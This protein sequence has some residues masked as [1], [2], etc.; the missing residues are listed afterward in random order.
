MFFFLST[1]SL[2]IGKHFPGIKWGSEN[3]DIEL[4][5][6]CDPLCSDCASVWPQLNQLV[7]MYK[8]LQIR[9]HTMPLS[10]HTWSYHSVK[11]VQA[12]KLLKGESKA[13]DMLDA[14]YNGDQIQFLNSR[15][16]NTSESGAIDKFCDYVSSKFGVDRAEYYEM[17][18]SM[19]TRKAAGAESTFAIIHGVLGTPTY[20]VNGARIDF[21]EETTTE[22]WTKFLDTLV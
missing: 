2:C 18:N 22:E 5:V 8:T 20:D 10:I 11:A 17:F 6:Y 12:L 21:D 9:F 3:P 1:K 7:D 19:D 15:M 4:D 16:M 13:R 14:L